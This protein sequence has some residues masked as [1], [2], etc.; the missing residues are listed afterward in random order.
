MAIWGK[1]IGAL[2]GYTLLRLPGAFLGY[3]IGSWFDR[4]L[5]L[6]LYRIPHSRA[7]AIQ[8]IFFKTSFLV[9]GYLCRADGRVNEKEIRAAERMMVRLNLN[10]ALRKE[11]IELF[12]EGKQQVVEI[13]EVVGRFLGEC[14]RYP[15]L[16]RLFV[17][18]QLEVALADGEVNKEEKTVLLRLCYLLGFSPQEFE[19]LQ[20]RYTASQAFHEWFSAQFQ[21]RAR[22]H[23]GQ[24]QSYNPQPSAGALDKAYGVLGVSIGAAN[25]EIKKAYRRLMNQHHPD[26]LAARGLPEGMV[27]VAKEKTQEIRAAYDLIR[28]ERGFR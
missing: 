12:N 2:L 22:M 17:E 14:R 3:L 8:Q 21:Q 23:G 6:H 24:Q 11:A 18:M 27:K 9:M 26:K 7:A 16:L 1:I 10:S 25:A 13:E 20:T 15:D 4:G 19:H 5:R 28:Q